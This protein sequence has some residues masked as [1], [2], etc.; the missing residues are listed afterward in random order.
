MISGNLVFMIWL[1]LEQREPRVERFTGYLL[2]VEEVLSI[3]KV[4]IDKMSQRTI[5]FSTEGGF[6]IINFFLAS[7]RLI[8]ASAHLIQFIQNEPLQILSL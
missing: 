4:F 8:K 5:D 2:Y 6:H 1:K 3:F 7:L